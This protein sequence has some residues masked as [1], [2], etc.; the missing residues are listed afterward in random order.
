MYTI[1]I[2]KKDACSKVCNASRSLYLEIDASDVGLGEVLL[3]VRKGMNCGND[4]IP[5]NVTLHPITFACKS[6]F[7]AKQC[8]RHFEWKASG[9]LHGLGKFHHYCFAKEV[10]LITD[11]MPLVAIISKDVAKMF[12]HLQCIMLYIHQYKVC[13][14][15][16]PG[17]DLHP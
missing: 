3:Q 5:Y 16:K 13:I 9:I 2:I 7:N 11:Q 6:L 1:K 4:E 8:Y 17:P 12:Q 15:Y 14:L 10:C